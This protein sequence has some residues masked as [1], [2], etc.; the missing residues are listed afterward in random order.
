MSSD[1]IQKELDR[2]WRKV[3]A[4]P[5]EASGRPVA[6][7]EFSLTDGPS[8][9]REVSMEAIS[10]LKRQHREEVMRL[11]QLLELKERSAG[12]FRGRLSAAENE[13]TSLRRKAQRQEEQIYQEVF[14]ASTELENAR[15]GFQEADNRFREEEKVLRSIA[16]NTRK[17]L[18]GETTRW[19]DVET[20]WNEREQQYLLEIKELETRA[21]RAQQQSAKTEGQARRAM[22]DLRE[23]KTAIEKTLGELLH[24]RRDREEAD[25]ERDKALTRMKEVEEHVQELQNLWQEERRQWQELWDRERSTW[26]TQ[27]QEFGAWEQKLRKE[28][29]AWHANLREVEN[30]ET[31]YAGQMA[32][33]LRKSSE[34]GEK[35]T[36]LLRRAAEKG[37]E[38]VAPEGKLRKA[39]KRLTWRQVLAAAAAVAVLAMAYP[40][41]KHLHRFEL[42]LV[43]SHAL[44]ADNP[45]GIAYDGDV[46]WLSQWDGQLLSLDPDDPSQ[47]LRRLTVDVKGPYHPNALDVW[48][49]ALYSLDS[50]QGRILRHPIGTPQKVAVS[51][52]SSGPAPVALAHDG[53]NLWSY[54]AATR[55]MYRHLGEGAE[56]ET[57]AYSIPL[58]ILPA[59]IRW[60]RDELWAYDAKG[61]QIVRFKKHGRALDVIDSHGFDTPVQSLLLALRSAGGEGPYLQMWS[62]SVPAAG[63][64][65]LKKYRVRH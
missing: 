14:D 52:P 63:L 28:R 41:W 44:E 29:E 24:E 22:Q 49:G 60:H 19:R 6:S 43:A 25:K 56:A 23:A 64:P 9:T 47:V 59:A 8:V 37:R 39:V 34:A 17:Q 21:Q 48:A 18:A 36:E 10:L 58:D 42:E 51:W 3:T 40:V 13:V 32:D 45:T 46:L 5:A 65:T 30:R 1:D 20:Q 50:A 38:V 57:E 7:P 4:G 27:R 54:D 55:S 62:L 35:V 2:L 31:K 53:Q 26:E 61:R 11:Q 12:E 15:K 16:E 33:I